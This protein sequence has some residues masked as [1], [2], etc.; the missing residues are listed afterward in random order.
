MRAES[1]CYADRLL[2]PRQ[3]MSFRV[4]DPEDSAEP[5]AV[6][7]SGTRA[8]LAT[9]ARTGQILTFVL[10]QSTVL[11]AC[12]FLFMTLREQQA[13]VPR[14]VPGEEAAEG[15][16]VLPIAG[17][18]LTLGAAAA[19]FLIPTMK[20]KSAAASYLATSERV[21][22]PIDPDATLTPGLTQFI[23]VWQSSALV[24]QALLEG[25]AIMNL[26]L[27]H[28]DG[29]RLHLAFAGACIIGITLHTPFVGR[30]HHA[31]ENMMN[32]QSLS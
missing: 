2:F 23:A 8:T 24:G 19:S 3:A 16:V 28:I 32:E 20:R 10:I 18:L 12:I 4:S 21:R 17:T 25:A 22:M 27:M 9:V 13:E 5:I 29:H 14:P 6:G 7:G 31:I 11:V 15:D 30:M 1:S 26:V